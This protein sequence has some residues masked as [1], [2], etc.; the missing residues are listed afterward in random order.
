MMLI[1]LK[2]FYKKSFLLLQ[3]E[4]IKISLL[5]VSLYFYACMGFLYYEIPHQPHL[6]W[7]DGIWWAIVTMTTV[8]YGDLFPI[9]FE[10][11]YFISIPTMVLGIGLLGYVISNVSV[12]LIETKSRKVKGMEKIE[13]E[14]HILIINFPNVVDE[15]EKIIDEI[16]IDESTK[17]KNICLI[18]EHLSS[19]PISLQKK[20]VSFIRGNP[21]KEVVLKQASIATASHA[22]VLSKDNTDPRSDDM[23][24]A[25][26]LMMRHLNEK[27]FSVVEVI[28]PEKVRQME[29]AGCN[30]AICLAHFS[31]NLIIQELQDPGVKT[32]IQELTSNT[33]GKQ[34]YLISNSNKKPLKYK[35]I[36]LSGLENHYSVLGVLKA[37]KPHLNPPSDT[38]VEKEDKIII[39][40]EYRARIE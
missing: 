35:Q 11:R 4:S 9:S 29:L 22:I 27:I 33:F 31:A 36:V 7:E 34:I 40:G 26:L 19:L 13:F 17:W 1:L 18:D 24:L 6:S 39:I 16:K 38:I 21:T 30:S 32:I 28:D 20:E 3:Q 15:L 5:F 25:I 14:N 8:G 23:N 37:N 10:G 2:G 12:K